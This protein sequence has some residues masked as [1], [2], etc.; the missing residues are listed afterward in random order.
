MRLSE[1][2]T[3]ITIDGHDSEVT[4]I[5]LDSREI[6]AG[7]VF[8]ALAGA[9][10]HGLE[11]AEQ[12]RQ[13]GAV[14]IV[15]DP[16]GQGSILADNVSGISL[17]VI[18]HLANKLGDIAARFYINPATR[19]K[20]IGVTGTNGKTSCSQFLA[21]LMDNCSVI[22]TLGWGQYPHL[23]NTI[24]T[25][26][27]AFALQK[28]LADFVVQGINHVAMEVSSHGLAQGRVNGLQFEGVVFTNLSRDHL[29]YHGSMDAY[30]QS[31]L[32][33]IRWP[34]V[35]FVV[36][37]K[38]DDYAQQVLDAI[39]TGVNR[40][41]FS[42]RNTLHARQSGLVA[43][44]IEY[45]MSGIACDIYWR[46]EQG[47][48]KVGLLGDFNLQNILAVL[49]VLL[50]MGQTLTKCLQ[51]IQSVKPVIGR[52]E[53]FYNSSGRPLVV[54]DYAHTPDALSKVLTTLR[55]HCHGL[56]TIVFGCGG[57]RDKG[58]RSEMGKIAEQLADRIVVTDDNPRYEDRQQIIND[59]IEGLNSRHVSVINDR[60]LAI[61]HAII[62]ST[63]QDV[64]VIA[65]KG[66]EDY[67]DVKGVKYPFSDRDCVQE[68]LAA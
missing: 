13:Q 22:G 12:V 30:F 42:I 61:E 3:D 49:A 7:G 63:K 21:Q 47:R 50:A 5:A 33:L 67:Q 34:G 60:K 2:L 58:K 65:G 41:T 26:P 62:N 29:D 6:N 44:N 45:T 43:D 57:D 39:A 52:M 48:L 19:L 4:H 27:D 54:V 20:V 16:A 53:C 10:H 64:V 23:Q 11:F 25:T 1:L 40:L 9:Q 38:D 32:R 56:L 28:I 55:Q 31:K 8:F 68:I 66:H 46:T 35:K 18:D 24:N 59:I 15:Y 17:Y 14:A 51:T 36:V 37:N